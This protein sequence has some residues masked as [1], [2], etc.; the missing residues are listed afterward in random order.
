MLSGSSDSK[1]HK[2]WMKLTGA[3]CQMRE[4]PRYYSV[5]LSEKGSQ[6]NAH[7]VQIERDLRRTFPEDLMFSKNKLINSM[8]NV[9]RAYSW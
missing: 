4:N 9:L 8:R 6:D 2:L 1:R 3:L 7:S 5:L